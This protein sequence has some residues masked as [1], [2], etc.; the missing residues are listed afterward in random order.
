[1]AKR[2]AQLLHVR[3]VC[4]PPPCW[5]DARV[6]ETAAQS[7]DTPPLLPPPA[8]QIN[9]GNEE[10]IRTAFIEMDTDGSGYLSGDELEAALAK[11]GLKFQRHQIISLRR[12]LD[13]DKSGA[14]SIEEFLHY[15]GIGTEA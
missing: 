12:K 14:V 5:L 7:A 9:Q 4:L 2:L 10:E 15:L 1:M 13:E 3:V 8:P 11:A 6:S